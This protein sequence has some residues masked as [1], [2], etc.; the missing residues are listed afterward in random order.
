MFVVG[1]FDRECGEPLG[2]LARS[3]C[4]VFGGRCWSANRDG[5]VGDRD[6]PTGKVLADHQPGSKMRRGEGTREVVAHL[7][8]DGVDRE[9]VGRVHELP[10]TIAKAV[11][12][13]SDRRPLHPIV[14]SPELVGGAVEQ[15]D[16]PE[17]AHPESRVGEQLVAFEGDDDGEV[18]TGVDSAGDGDAPELAADGETEPFEH[19]GEQRGVL[20]AVATAA[21]TDELVRDRVETDAAMLVQHDVDV[22][23]RERPDVRRKELVE[24]RPARSPAFDAHALE[25]VVDIDEGGLPRIVGHG[26]RLRRDLALVHRGI[27]ARPVRPN[28]EA[29]DGGAAVASRRGDREPRRRIE[30]ASWP[31]RILSAV[32]R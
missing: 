31:D 27:E 28:R 26:L 29:G 13:P 5:A 4:A 10:A 9:F 3:Q 21:T 6:M 24:Q 12:F 16:R 11:E 20:E 7:H 25:V 2:Q 1:Q 18:C 17:Q 32:R 14:P 15:R 8:V 22:V 19:G 23:E 30:R